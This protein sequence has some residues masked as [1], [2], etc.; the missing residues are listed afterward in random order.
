M[1]HDKGTNAGM[2]VIWCLGMYASGSTW[3]FNVVL[4]TAA[5]LVPEW[6]A[7]GRFITSR[8]ELDFLDEPA[9]TS[10]VK[11]HDTDSVAAEM[12]AR[13]ADAIL[14]SLRDPR[15][16]VTSLMLYQQHPFPDALDWTEAAARFCSRMTAHP[17]AVV[18]RYESGF[19][20][21]PATLD[22]IAACFARPLAPA[23]RARIFAETRRQAI[24]HLIARL[25]TLPTALRDEASGDVVDLATQWHTHHANRTGEIGRW[26]HM[27]S[28]D[29]VA[30][31]ERRLGDW[32]RALGYQPDHATA[33]AKP[34]A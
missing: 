14:V 28:R 31:T 26:R 29:Q 8:A 24:E 6:P 19:I 11:S 20:N 30:E 7:V 32:M 22:Q 4:K 33:P 12:L 2:R 5:A 9:T 13:R 17:R 16:C 23:D 10:V 21:A 15:D 25:E 3:V 34:T 1:L 18:L 27:L